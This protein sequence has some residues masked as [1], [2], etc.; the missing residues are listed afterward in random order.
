MEVVGVEGREARRQ[1]RQ[2]GENQCL[3]PTEDSFL[4]HSLSKIK[5]WNWK[6]GPRDK[7]RDLT[8]VAACV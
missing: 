2:R 4:I 1:R 5:P 3:P 8:E 6:I 7:P